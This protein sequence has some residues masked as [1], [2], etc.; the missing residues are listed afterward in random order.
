M[1]AQHNFNVVILMLIEHYV[2]NVL[3]SIYFKCPKATKVLFKGYLSIL[4]WPYLEAHIYNEIHS[5]SS[6]RSDAECNR[7][8]PDACINY[9]GSYSRY[10]RTLCT[11]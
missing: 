10:R 2:N 7:S 1:L 6:S 8:G 5:L 4:I 3:L 11:G 9:V